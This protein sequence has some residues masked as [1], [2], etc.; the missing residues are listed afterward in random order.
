MI[1]L[2]LIV[3]GLWLMAS[4]FRRLKRGLKMLRQPRTVRWH[5]MPPGLLDRAVEQTL[6]RM[7]KI[8]IGSGNW[9]A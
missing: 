5:Y 9:A 1:S 4:G 6:K 7:N 2:L 3:G 8:A